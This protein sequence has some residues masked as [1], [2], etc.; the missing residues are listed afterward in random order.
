MS[1]NGVVAKLIDI[2]RPGP[3]VYR[4]RQRRNEEF[5]HRFPY[6][7]NMRV[8]DLVVR[9]SAPYWRIQR[10]VA[11]VELTSVTEMRSYFPAGEI[12]FER[13]AGLPKSLVAVRRRND[14]GQENP[15]FA[16][17]RAPGLSS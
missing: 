17:T 12:W 7:A 13:L 4:S 5:N 3:F 16:K 9:E 14:D 11:S 2:A 15:G 6:L 10:L 1:S 8:L